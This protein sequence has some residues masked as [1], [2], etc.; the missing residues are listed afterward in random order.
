MVALLAIELAVVEA[1]LV[2]LRIGTVPLPVCVLLAMVGNV[3][4]PRLAAS[5]S[6]QPA[7]AVVPP[8]LWLVVV[9]L[10]SAPRAEGDLVVPGTLTGLAFLFGGCVAGAYGAVSTIARRRPRSRPTTRG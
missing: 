7:V 1:F 3:A 6:R 5:L 9:L 2:P 8:V 10:L 4:L